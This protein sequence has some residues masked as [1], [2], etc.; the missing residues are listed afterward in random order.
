MF[1]KLLQEYAETDEAKGSKLELSKHLTYSLASVVEL[2]PNQPLLWGRA[3]FDSCH[4]R[5]A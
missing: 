2:K 3:R 5:D 4:E 1:V